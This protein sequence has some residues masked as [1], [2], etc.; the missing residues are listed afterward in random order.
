M[1]T[2][3]QLIS[4]AVFVIVMILV[5]SEKIHRT[6]AALLGAMALIV[7]GVI[8]WETGIHHVDFETIG[9]LLGMMLFVSV[10]KESG[11]FEFAAIKAAKM[12]KGKPWAIMV[13]FMIITAALSALL[14]NV[15]T[16]LL[17]GPMTLIVCDLLE[18]NPVPYFLVEV[19]ASNIGGTA[20]LIGDPPNIMIGSAAPFSFADF[21]MVDT[22]AAILCLIVSIFAFKFVFGRKLDVT[23][24]NRKKVLDLNPADYIRDRALFKKSLVMIVVVVALFM[25]HGTLHLDSCVIALGVAGVM[26]VLG[27]ADLEMCVFGIEWTTILFF[28]GLFIV[29]GGMAETG[30]IAMMA[31]GIVAICGGSPL[32]MM[33]VILWASGIISAILDNIPF[34]ATMIPVIQTIEAGGEID[35]IPLWWALSLGA[36][37]GGNGTLIGASANVV[38]CSIAGKNG[39]PISFMEFTKYGFPV[40]ILTLIVATGYMFV[41]YGLAMM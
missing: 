16:V 32:V 38:L 17:V 22:P 8:D 28:C 3:A 26:V 6:V 33:L 11:L 21:V 23:E 13:A 29:V 20:T 41:R 30:V 14:D 4:I 39:H 24:E 12:A 18:I 7:L 25:L 1:F 15:T 31:E 36:C 19:F 2:T 5:I 34:C 9:V 27:K 10:V 37:L 40:M 35:V